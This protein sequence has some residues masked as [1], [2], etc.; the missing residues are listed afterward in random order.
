M[1]LR[2]WYGF[3]WHQ[4][5][6]DLR[7]ARTAYKTHEQ[8]L[9]AMRR[10]HAEISHQVEESRTTLQEKRHALE[11]AHKTLSELHRD[12]ERSSRELAILEERR[13]SYKQ[14][15]QDLEIDL[16]NVEEALSGLETQE[17]G[18]TEEIDQRTAEYNAA[19]DEVNKV[20]AKLAEIKRQK[21]K[22]K[23]RSFLKPARSESGW[24]QKIYN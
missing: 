8:Q 20:D 24:K 2:E 1:L 11:L 14:Q 7:N 13:R 18:F 5:Q 19:L 23:K 12:F 9:S 17:I 10:E 22:P 16:A 21:R 15:Q 3:H 6:D 4:K